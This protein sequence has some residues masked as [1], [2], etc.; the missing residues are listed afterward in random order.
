MTRPPENLS[1]AAAEE[2][3]FFSPVTLAGIQTSARK[4]L[5][6]QDG[7][8]PV[9]IIHGLFEAAKTVREGSVPL[10]QHPALILYLNK[11]ADLLGYDHT[12]EQWNTA[13][14]AAEFL[15]SNPH[16]G[17]PEYEHIRTW[18][19]EQFIL[20]LYDTHKVKA[21]KS[22]LAY[23]FYDGAYG[24]QPV[25]RGEDFGCSPLHSIDSD[26]AVAALL[27]FL[28]LRPG[29]TDLEYFDDYL[30]EQVEWAEIHG[31]LLGLL[32]MEL[33]ESTDK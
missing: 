30:P 28:S 33:V 19:Q 22:R 24:G 16:L 15:S 17:F 8:N 13:R 4:A 12:H 7:C 1:T 32:A 29:D 3:R 31:E 10:Y 25:F 5:L 11:I 23:E 21:N 26:Q 27:G 9:G 14:K 6:A 2:N 20:Y 18:R